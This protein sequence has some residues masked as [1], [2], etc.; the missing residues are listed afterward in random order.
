[1]VLFPAA[2]AGMVDVSLGLD[3][4]VRIFILDCERC[5]MVSREVSVNRLE[6]VVTIVAV[7]M[8][9]FGIWWLLATLAGYAEV[10][11]WAVTG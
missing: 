1:M 7:V 8:F 10:F 5:D 4:F 11:W 3:C 6:E 2:E 9:A